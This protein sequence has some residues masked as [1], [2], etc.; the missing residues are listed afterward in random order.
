VGV[1]LGVSYSEETIVECIL[2]EGNR[3]ECLDLVASVCYCSLIVHVS[4]VLKYWTCKLL[5]SDL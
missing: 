5:L 1:K 4:F 3:E 2:E